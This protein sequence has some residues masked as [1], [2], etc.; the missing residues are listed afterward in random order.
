M[1]VIVNTTCDINNAIF[2]EKIKK[3]HHSSGVTLS[4][5]KLQ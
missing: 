4:S 2:I 3:L 1:E 5:T